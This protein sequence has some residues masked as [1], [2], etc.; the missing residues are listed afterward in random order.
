M[1]QVCQ[2]MTQMS[3]YYARLFKSVEERRK[4]KHVFVV[5]AVTA[6]RTWVWSLAARLELAVIPPRPLISIDQAEIVLLVH[7]Y[8]SASR[9]RP[10][11]GP[12]T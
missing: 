7:E 9:W 3:L 12:P 4:S 6:V 11:L 10:S 5:S 1:G 8:E 2:L